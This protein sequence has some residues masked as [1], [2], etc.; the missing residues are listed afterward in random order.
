MEPV[1]L[2][3]VLRNPQN[4]ISALCT[5]TTRANIKRDYLRIIA[6]KTMLILRLYILYSVQVIAWNW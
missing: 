3:I 6:I 4:Q 2:R 1:L 5:N